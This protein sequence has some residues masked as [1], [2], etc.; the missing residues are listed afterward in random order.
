MLKV[1][2]AAVAA[3]AVVAVVWPWYRRTLQRYALRAIDRHQFPPYL[4]QKL[5]KA[6][7]NLGDAQALEVERGLR[8]FF[9]ASAQARGRF[10]AMPSQAVDA[11]WHEFILHTRGYEVFCRKAFGRMLH[12]TPAEALPP[13]PLGKARNSTQHEGLRRAWRLACQDERIDPH[14]PKRLPLLFA[15]DASLGIAGGYVY[16]LDCA[17][18]G[19][20][21]GGTHCASDL[22]SR[23]GSGGG[24]EDGSSSIDDAGDAGDG[25]GDGGGGCGSCGGD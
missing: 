7:P 19:A 10:V 3:V 21:R 1:W 14:K 17:A 9:R 24:G 15:L 8:Q 6:Y 13:A 2:M 22:S 12:H 25:G 23:D 20:D 11:L 4:K 18:L 5:L 16:A